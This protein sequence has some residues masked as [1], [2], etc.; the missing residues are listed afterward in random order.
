M[1]DS[2]FQSP[3]RAPVRPSSCQSIISFGERIAAC[4]GLGLGLGLGFRVWGLG[5]RVW[6]LVFR[7][8]AQGLQGMTGF[9]VPRFRSLG[10]GTPI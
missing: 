5:F 2:R 1:P 7:V 10:Y 9:K 4:K 6:G 3:G 8:R